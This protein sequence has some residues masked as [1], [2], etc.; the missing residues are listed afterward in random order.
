M[1]NLFASI[2]ALI[3]LWSGNVKAAE[4]DKPYQ[5]SL[6]E[7]WRNVSEP[8]VI[9]YESPDGKQQL[10][11]GE[12]TIKKSLKNDE[13]RALLK[14]FVEVRLNAETELSNGAAAVGKVSYSGVASTLISEYW[15][16]RDS[17]K[18]HFATVVYATP[19]RL[20][21]FRFESADGSQPALQQTVL[22]PKQ[23]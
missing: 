12:Y 4:T 22:A 5:F 14:Q 23:N 18:I 10:V 8:D 9:A 7:G 2:A 21:S 15:G 20:L 1:R 3:V 13:L 16:T 17:L 11:I 19:S 6:P